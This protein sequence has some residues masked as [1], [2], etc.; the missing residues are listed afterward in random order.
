MVFSSFLKLK[1]NAG[2]SVYVYRFLAVY[3]KSFINDFLTIQAITELVFK[4]DI[5]I[6][7]KKTNN[8][9]ASIN[10]QIYNPPIKYSVVEISLIQMNNKL[11]KNNAGIRKITTNNCMFFLI[12][13]TSINKNRKEL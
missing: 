1:D 9:G 10:K 8:R 3:S 13:I 5:L 6:F 7:L 12:F 2:L 11:I 4:R